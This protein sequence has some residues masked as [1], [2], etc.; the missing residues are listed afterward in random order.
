L[1]L[2]P[3]LAFSLMKQLARDEVPLSKR[4]LTLALPQSSALALVPRSEPHRP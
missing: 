1:T 2:R 3:S 4:V